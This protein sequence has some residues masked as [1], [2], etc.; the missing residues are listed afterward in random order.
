MVAAAAAAGA[1]TRSGLELPGVEQPL[2]QNP[3]VAT[4]RGLELPGVEQP[5]TPESHYDLRSPSQSRASRR[6]AATATPSGKRLQ[7]ISSRASRRRAATAASSLHRTS[8]QIG[9]DEVSSF[10][11]SSSHC[12]RLHG[13]SSFQASSNHCD[14]LVRGGLELPGVEQPQ[15]PMPR[16]HEL[17]VSS[18]QASSSH[19]G[20]TNRLSRASRRRAATAPR[21]V[22]TLL[23]LVSSF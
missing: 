7:D 22:S 15:Q 6:R 19:Y 1:T 4:G 5:S 13:V 18:F 10:Q 3:S 20:G 8:W 16:N 14:L 12:V 23:S 11:A 21:D 2:R 17:M 9:V